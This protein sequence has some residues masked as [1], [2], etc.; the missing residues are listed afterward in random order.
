[1]IQSQQTPFMSSPTTHPPEFVAVVLASSIGKRLYPMSSEE[2]PKHMLP[3]VGIPILFRLLQT[4]EACGFIET[5]IT[6]RSDDTVTRDAFLKEGPLYNHP[7]TVVKSMNDT[8][9]VDNNDNLDN[10]PTM[11][12]LIL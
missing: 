10:T 9:N 12:I 2:L 4:L 7:Y 3:M 6:L 11:P 8:S 1:M 5:I